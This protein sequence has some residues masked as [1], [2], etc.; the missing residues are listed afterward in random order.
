MNEEEIQKRNF[1]ISD[2][3]N[4]FQK[5]QNSDVEFNVLIQNILNEKNK[6]VLFGSFGKNL[7]NFLGVVER[8]HPEFFVFLRHNLFPDEV[9]KKMNDLICVHKYCK[10]KK[11]N[12]VHNL[13][14]LCKEFLPEKTIT[15]AK[16][17][18]D[19][20]ASKVH[21]RFLRHDDRWVVRHCKKSTKIQTYKKNLELEPEDKN[22]DVF[23]CYHHNSDA[24]KDILVDLRKKE[25][26]FRSISCQNLANETSA[27]INRLESDLNSQSLGFHRI[28]LNAVARNIHKIENAENNR[29]IKIHPVT[30]DWYHNNKHLN[31][32]IGICEN[33]P[34]YG[35]N[36]PVFDH[37]GV[38]KFDDAKTGIVVGERDTQAF[39]VGYY[40]E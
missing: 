30:Q 3:I 35:N 13:N 4:A 38:I 8:S 9:S 26:N 28:T 17:V 2:S 7:Q 21:T 24:I 37:Y 1:K 5:I 20:F 16:T 12:I 11:L 19:L 39:F 18:D 36:Y 10:R 34:L 29:E 22:Y 33:F 6:D 23:L 14:V 32:L 25:Q 40:H 31:D 15:A 27:A